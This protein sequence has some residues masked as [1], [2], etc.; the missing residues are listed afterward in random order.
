MP[1]GL[2]GRGQAAAWLTVRQD[3][4]WGRGRGHG[5]GGSVGVGN[6]NKTAAAEWESLG[7][8]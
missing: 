8:S 2:A 7:A 3:P 6:V 1:G 4:L 5:V